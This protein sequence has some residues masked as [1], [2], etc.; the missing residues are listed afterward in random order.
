M[1]TKYIAVI[2]VALCALSFNAQTVISTSGVSS[3]STNVS[4]EGTIGEPITHT[5]TGANATLTQGFQQTG[6]EVVGITENEAFQVSVFPNPT[7]DNLTISAENTLIQAIVITDI[8]G[9]IIAKSEG[10]VA[11]WTYD[12]S[13]QPNGTYLINVKKDSNTFNTYKIIKTK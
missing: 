10:E 1:K 13:S 8:N 12:L 5:Y 2:V 4:L 7:A 6:L 9:K 11:T 3:Q